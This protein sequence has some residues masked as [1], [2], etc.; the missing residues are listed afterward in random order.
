VLTVLLGAE[1]VSVQP[2]SLVDLLINTFTFVFLREPA[3]ILMAR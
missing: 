2:E 1:A 3:L